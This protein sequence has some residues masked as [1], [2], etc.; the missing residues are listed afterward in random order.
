MS[1]VSENRNFAHNRANRLF[2]SM[3]TLYQSRLYSMTI[4][5]IDLTYLNR[6]K[7]NEDEF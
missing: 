7:P 5:M 3:L 1:T 4:D 6:S 2:V